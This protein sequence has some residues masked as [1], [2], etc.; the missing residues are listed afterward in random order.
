[1]TDF[2]VERIWLQK[3]EYRS[4][5]G[6]PTKFPDDDTT[7]AGALLSDMLRNS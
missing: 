7:E 4:R 6:G 1:M 2:F 5:D 3:D